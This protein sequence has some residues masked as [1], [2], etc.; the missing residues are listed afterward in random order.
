M[1]NTGLYL[2]SEGFDASCVLNHLS[3]VLFFGLSF[4]WVELSVF[5]FY[6]LF[7]DLCFNFR[8]DKTLINPARSTSGGSSSSVPFRRA[9]TDLSCLK[10]TSD[11]FSVSPDQSGGKRSSQQEKNQIR[12]E[13]K[14][15]LRTKK[16]VKGKRSGGQ[17]LLDVPPQFSSGADESY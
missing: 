13:S 15:N 5:F 12:E 3:W 11:V 17:N 8:P 14:S 10:R 4:F 7:F 6:C 16:W 9:A 2:C 1:C